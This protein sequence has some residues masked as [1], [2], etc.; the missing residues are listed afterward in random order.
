MEKNI[1]MPCKVI[2]NILSEG[3]SYFVIPEHELETLQKL[4]DSEN[5]SVIKG[6]LD[7]IEFNIHETILI[8]MAILILHNNELVYLQEIDTTSIAAKTEAMY[9]SGNI[10][11]STKDK[12]A[13]T[14]IY[15]AG[16]T[17]A[18]IFVLLGMSFLVLKDCKEI[19][20]PSFA[21]QSMYHACSTIQNIIPTNQLQITI[22]VTDTNKLLQ[23]IDITGN[24]I[25]QAIAGSIIKTYEE[26]KLYR[27]INSLDYSPEF[28]EK[29]AIDLLMGG[30]KLNIFEKPTYKKFTNLMVGIQDNTLEKTANGNYLIEGDEI[31]KEYSKEDLDIIA[32][33]WNKRQKI[34]KK[35]LVTR[36]TEIIPLLSSS[37]TT[38]S[39]TSLNRFMLYDFT[40]K[41]YNIDNFI[42]SLVS[43]M[44]HL[45]L[46]SSWLLKSLSKE[47][48]ESSILQSKIINNEF[49]A[50]K[51]TNSIREDLVVSLLGFF[52]GIATLCLV[53]YDIVS[54]IT[55]N[56]KYETFIDVVI[57][58]IPTVM[59]INL[60]TAALRSIVLINAPKSKSYH[61]IGRI[62][63]ESYI[64]SGITPASE[65][66]NSVLLLQI[67]Y[68]LTR[69]VQIGTA[70]GVHRDTDP[71]RVIINWVVR[72]LGMFGVKSNSIN[73]VHKTTHRISTNQC[74]TR[75]IFL[76]A[77]LIP[78]L[79][80]RIHEQ[81]KTPADL[82]SDITTLGYYQKWYIATG[83]NF[84]NNNSGNILNCGVFISS[85]VNLYEY[86]TFGMLKL[87]LKAGFDFNKS[88]TTPK[89][90]LTEAW[91]S[92]N[93]PLALG[94]IK[95]LKACL[96]NMDLRESIYLDAMVNFWSYGEFNTKFSKT[97][98]I[99]KLIRKY[100]N[101]S[102]DTYFLEKEKEDLKELYILLKIQNRKNE[103]R[104]L[105]DLDTFINNH[106][107][108]VN[109]ITKLKSYKNHEM[110]RQESIKIPEYPFAIYIDC[111]HRWAKIH[112]NR[113]FEMVPSELPQ[114]INMDYLKYLKP[115]NNL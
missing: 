114:I 113:T 88:V 95:H 47:D 41:D 46:D 70:P 54:R 56:S 86:H 40:Q 103:V 5:N 68:G 43:N 38:S 19:E 91:L 71:N 33:A 31:D 42:Y 89:P 2:K 96:K 45:E 21:S 85:L 87:V 63:R 62:N 77:Y 53:P 18:K 82:N 72:M 22:P 30:R 79:M 59:K 80:E 11:I 14:V 100:S 102:Y 101:S 60:V 37:S 66:F 94:E 81:S 104:N 67:F 58:I 76:T 6:Y 20:F 13:T 36:V 52:A 49:E 44:H 27:E 75:I 23:G 55:L 98:E 105:K 15:Y 84:L 115:G 99:F 57:N 4:S 35:G 39:S 16:T 3:N 106:K 74:T 90:S 65:I 110:A 28:K 73:T 107:A 109:N 93:D 50:S 26:Y 64:L 9:T 112:L 12:S 108:F 69:L 97:A 32:A 24:F 78:T 61:S 83:F 29:L 25:S 51:E 17:L 10:G 48:I 92:E 8:D 111:W 1:F 7:L 34:M